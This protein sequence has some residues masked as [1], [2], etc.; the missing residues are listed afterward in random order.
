MLL[1]SYYFYTSN[2]QWLILLIILSTSIDYFAALGIDATSDNGKRKKWLL[3]S[4][5]SNLSILGFFKYY[6]FFAQNV[7]DLAGHMGIT[8]SWIDLNII[9]PIGISFF[10]FQSMSY[11]I[12]VYRRNMPVERSFYRFAF[13]VAYFPQLIAG[14]IVRA[15]E[16]I[17]Q[18]SLR[19]KLDIKIGRAHV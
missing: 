13:F 6:N 19:P 2:S 5:I 18:I 14:P 1:A 17:P 15:K 16:F 7:A 8:L 4:I 11:T 10:T 9:L 12:D 3:L